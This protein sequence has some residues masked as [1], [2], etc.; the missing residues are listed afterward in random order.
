MDSLERPVHPLAN[1]GLML[2]PIE[3][4][5]GGALRVC[6]L[7]RL[8][9]DAASGPFVLLRELPGAR[10]YLGAVVDADARIQEWVEVWVQTSEL[11]D[12]NFSTRHE[13]L[14]NSTFDEHWRADYA[15]A[16]FSVPETV[17]VTGMELNS[18]RPV[19]ISKVL[20][21][22]SLLASAQPAAW[23]LC[24]DDALLESAGLPP[25]SL[26]PF[27]YLY[28][29]NATGARTFLA[30]GSDMPANAQVQGLDRLQTAPGSAEVFNPHAG[31]IRVQ[32][33]SPLGFEEHLQALEG[34]PWEP[35]A[36]AGV[37]LFQNGVYADLQAWSGSP[38]GM[39]FLLNTTVAPDR[40]NEVFF[41]KLSALLGVFKE[42]RA[43]VKARQLPLL[44]LT[45]S[46][47]SIRLPQAGEQFPG[48]WTARCSLTKPGQAYPLQ[49]KSSEQK[50]FIRLGKVEPSPYLPEGLGAHSFGI[51]SVRRRNVVV[52]ADGVVL[53]GTLVAEDYLKLDSHDL[54]W[55][56]LPVGEE[57]FEFW[58]HVFTAEAVGPREARFR[59][60]P[61]KL[62]EAVVTVLKNTA[63]FA[64]APYEIW[65]LL[66]S[67][68]D[69][70]SLGIIAIRALLANSKTNLP[71]V[72]D[73]ILGLA[74]HIGKD[75]GK[76]EQPAGKL[77]DLLERDPKL[78]DLVSPRA[79]VEQER[80]PHQARALICL[81]VWFDAMSW[82]L[83]L[84]P[85]TGAQSYCKDFGDV[86]PLALENV[87]DAPIQELEGLVLRMRGLLAPGAWANAEIAAAL[88]DEMGRE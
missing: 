35:V 70:H 77:K 32:R 44:N 53:E 10:I 46:S 17:I 66:S 86:S 72:V 64:K 33:F 45:P 80:T 41:L 29:P 18:P 58:A 75:P 69:L 38:K 39:P 57:R 52:E 48:L 8:Q 37:R 84:F 5:L 3:G 47:F 73:D 19:L 22:K 61:M 21:P 54:L 24:K 36:Q 65:P 26:S 59:T 13:L 27:R 68:C 11:R 51:G 88:R 1:S 25:Y 85:G 63:A 28:D 31:F 83:R 23:Q 4:G 16:L 34:R 9:P 40:L 71:A 12:L 56:K 2:A 76:Q 60:V 87:F 55:F 67:P 82:L 6:V 74:R 78:L 15:A 14:T 43:C 79:M 62:P 30:T 50:Y 81:P 20:P 49:L 7:M 42:V